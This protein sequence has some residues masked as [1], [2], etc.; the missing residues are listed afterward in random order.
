[1]ADTLL[2]SHDHLAG[3]TVLE[4]GTGLGL[5]GIILARIPRVRAFL[6]DHCP[7]VLDLCARNLAR[8]R[9]QGEDPSAVTLRRLDWATPPEDCWVTRALH[10]DVTS[11]ASEGEGEGEDGYE[12]RPADRGALRECTVVLGADVIYCDELTEALMD[13]LLMLLRPRSLA[14]PPHASMGLLTLEKRL[15]FSLQHLRVVANGYDTLRRRVHEVASVCVSKAGAPSPTPRLLGRR[16]EVRSIPQRFRYQRGNDLELWKV[17][18][19]END[20]PPFLLPA[21]EPAEPGVQ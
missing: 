17:W 13:K 21:I 6:T 14:T 15:N 19:S 12:W 8:N 9:A 18:C 7:R 2:A 3:R 5:S 1:M 11:T 4:L 20:E 10:G 16:V